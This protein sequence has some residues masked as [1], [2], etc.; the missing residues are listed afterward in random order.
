MEVEHSRLTGSFDH[1][2]RELDFGPKTEKKLRSEFSIDSIEVLLAAKS[3]LAYGKL[4]GIEPYDQLRLYF[5]VEW[6]ITFGVGNMMNHFQHNEFNK[7]FQKKLNQLQVQ[8][9]CVTPSYIE[10][11]PSASDVVPPIVA[12]LASEN[13]G[14]AAQKSPDDAEE[15]DSNENDDPDI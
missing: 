14:F 3:D 7:Y 9:I 5:V 15:S 4:T 10:Y 1:V 6:I 2:M 11:I 13:Y 12:V 8:E